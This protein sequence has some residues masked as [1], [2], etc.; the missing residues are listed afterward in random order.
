MLRNYWKITVRT[1]LKNKVYTLTT[2]LGLTIGLAACGLIALYIFD[3]W[4]VDRFHEKGHRIYRVVTNTVTKGE[5]ERAANTVGRPLAQAIRQEVP[6]IES[7]VQVHWANFPIKNK[8]RYFYDRELY[9]G[10][11]FLTT[12]TFPL[13]EGDPKTALRD[14]YSLVLTENMARKYFGDGPVLGKTL[15]LSD[16]LPFKITGVLADPPPSHLSFQVLLS[17]ATYYAVGN[18]TEGEWFTWDEFCYVLLPENANPAVAEKK[19]SA[20]PMK[21]NGEEYRNNGIYV[22]HSLEAMPSIYLHSTGIPDPGGA[23]RTTGSAQQLQLL[24]VIGLFLLLL[25]GI[26]FVNLTTAHQGERAKEVGVR[27]AIGA[28]YTA[29]LGQF[30]GES[31]LLAFLAGLLAV[32]VM[33]LTLP[34]LN[35]L[36]GKTISPV[37]LSQPVTV[38]IGVG[39]LALTG[40]LAGW[41]PALLLAR[42]R[43]VDTL[44]G[45]IVTA[46]GAWMRRGLVV[47]Q[48]SISLILIISTIVVV[49]QL[50]F[51]QSQNLGF[52]KERVLS[53][54]LRKLP[55]MDF[56]NNYESLKQQVASLPNVKSVTGVSALPGRDGWNGQIVYPEGRP[57]DQTLSMEVIPVDHD[58][59]KTLGLTLRAGRDYSKRFAMDAKQGVLLN[60]AACRAIGWK[61]EEAIG[62]R[63][64]S[65][66]LEDGRVVGVI[67]DF[68]QHGLQQ[69]I[70]PILT[71]ITP[72]YTYRYLSLRL[73][74]GDLRTS[75]AEVERFWQKRF[76]GY[77]FDYYFLDEDFNRQY[78]TEQQLSTLFGLFAGLAILIAC[79]GLFA[80][81]TY[82]AERRTKEIGVRKV[83]G[84][85]VA[86][87]VRLL[88]KDFLQLVIIAILL[89][90]PIAWYAMNDWLADFAYRISVD[91]WVFALAG[92]GAVGI[93]FLTVSFQSIRAALMNPVK[94][95]RSE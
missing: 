60:E 24:G 89:A 46:K 37:I 8:N 74:T 52:N 71:F 6:E 86:N 87:I 29:L 26:N 10:A 32:L 44:K 79:L 57:H 61:P 21:Y 22:T 56:I 78:K 59:V 94:S 90:S 25:A 9:V 93:A 38:L 51:M 15:M 5:T 2:V 75:V 49:R 54:E 48:F 69:K 40:L 83:L 84:A 27:K 16:T 72:A 12:F 1:L 81:T 80:L 39:F 34:F 33:H 62:K 43:P 70:K 30:L 68:H 13:L 18:S 42:F 82:T 28:A 14:P 67:A 92:F 17:M 11:D 36:T 19:I 55:R 45:Q 77:D 7:I 31:L 58:Y 47:F 73:G 35:E 88:S 4:G 65:S 3:E 91:W 76:P 50:R 23:N 53:I 20:L 63:V 64:Q 85:S 95:L 41:Y 66:G